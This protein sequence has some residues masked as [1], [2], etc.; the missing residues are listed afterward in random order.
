MKLIKVY[1]MNDKGIFLSAPRPHLSFILR[2]L[3]PTKP[4]QIT[5]PQGRLRQPMGGVLTPYT[6]LLN[7]GTKREILLPTTLSHVNLVRSAGAPQPSS[8][9]NCI[10]RRIALRQSR[11]RV[12]RT[13]VEWSWCFQLLTIFKYIIL[14]Q[15][16]A[17]K[18]D[19]KDPSTPGFG[20]LQGNI[21]F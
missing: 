13:G 9:L 3:H 20:T 17:P 7:E 6:L 10:V 21:R 16:N 18:K 2:H 4:S 8:Q 11:C 1:K 14:R 15:S 19:S 12:A 5:S